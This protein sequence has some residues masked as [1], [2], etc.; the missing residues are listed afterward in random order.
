MP[1]P[2]TLV[3]SQSVGEPRFRLEVNWDPDTIPAFLALPAAES[4]G[5]TLPIDPYLLEPLEHYLRTFEIDL[6]ANARVALQDLRKEHASAVVE[7]RRSRA[8]DGEVLETE[9]RLGGELRPFQR[10]AV[11]YARWSRR[12]F[13]ADEQGLGKTIEALATLE[14]DD[15]FPAVVLCP[16]SLKLN[17][18]REAHKWL[19]HRKITVLKGTGVAPD[20]GADITI[21]NYEIV[22]AHA[23]RLALRQPSALILDESHYVKNPRAKRT[24]AT[25][26][27]AFSLQ[28]DALRLALTGTP[29]MNHPEELIAQLR[30]IGRLEDFGS[31][32]KF[33]RRFQGAGA[34]ERIHWHLRRRCFVRR[35]KS[36]GA[37]PAAGQA[38]G[39]RP[40]RA[41]QRAR[42]PAGRGRR[43]RLAARAAARAER[44]GGARRRHAAGRA[45]RPAQRPQAPGRPRQA[46]RRAGLDRR[47]HPVRGAAGGLLR[48]T[49]GPGGAHPALPRRPPHRRRRRDRAPRGGG[50][51]LPGRGRA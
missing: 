38:P 9:D 17:W 42:V 5:R 4:H 25:R 30:I 7:V 35:L 28:P 20:D 34:E 15:A 26:K 1:A 6:A 47:L 39:R 27:L 50:S 12:C 51:P 31:G 21:L 49:R 8:R 36:R 2:A 3:Y 45:P 29:V 19:P 41:R 18:Q 10:A 46:R 33:A 40:R 32:A 22:A 48:L 16:A 44:A 13:I 11:H 14:E 24:A 23:A 43:R 37:A